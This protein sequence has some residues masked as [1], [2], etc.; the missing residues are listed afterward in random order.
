MTTDIQKQ[1]DKLCSIYE[2][3]EKSTTPK[4]IL[5]QLYTIVS[6]LRTNSAFFEKVN[7]EKNKICITL[8]QPAKT[9]LESIHKAYQETEEYYH[10][11]QIEIPQENIIPLREIT[12]TDSTLLLESHLIEHCYGSMIGL[13]THLMTVNA[14]SREAAF[15]FVSQIAIIH[16]MNNRITISQ[17]VSIESL[18]ILFHQ[19]KSFIDQ[20]KIYNKILEKN[21]K[22]FE[23]CPHVEERYPQKKGACK[24][25]D[26]L[27]CKY[28]ALISILQLLINKQLTSS[29]HILHVQ[30]YANINPQ[31]EVLSWLHDKEYDEFLMEKNKIKNTKSTTVWDATEKLIV[32]CESYDAYGLEA[33]ISKSYDGTRIHGLC[34]IDEYYQCVLIISNFTENKEESLNQEVIKPT[35]K[36]FQK[37]EIPVKLHIESSQITLSDEQKNIQ[38]PFDRYVNRKK[39]QEEPNR[40]R[41]IILV[42]QHYPKPLSKKMIAN[43]LQITVKQVTT[44]CRGAN[45]EIEKK[46]PNIKQYIDARSITNKVKI[47]DSYPTIVT[48]E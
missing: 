14:P 3:G 42:A 22:K 9:A 29:H 16:D 35:K 7:S 8:M 6:P 12:T 11:N 43:T 26:L 45:E 30:K 15:N 23:N 33:I 19:V 39:K 32:F 10:A 24:N 37:K 34:E 31:G 44:A 4:I 18:N 36:A 25:Q 5:P 17:P 40:W 46:M 41:V 20:H 1:L 48:S 2:K 38:M 28:S 21:I 27:L 47:N 13:I